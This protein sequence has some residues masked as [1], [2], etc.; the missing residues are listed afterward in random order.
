MLYV[1]ADKAASAELLDEGRQPPVP[2]NQDLPQAAK[3]GS[4]RAQ[5]GPS[6][7]WHWGVDLP[8]ATDTAVVAPERMTIAYVWTDNTT[9]PF[10]GYGPAGVL[11]QGKSGRWHLLAHLDPKAWTA[12]GAAPPAPQKVYEK[13]E[14][15]GFPSP[16]GGEGVGTAQPHT[17]WEVRVNPID[18]PSTRKANTLDPIAWLGGVDRVKERS[19]SGGLLILLALLLYGSRKR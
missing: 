11:A 15:V 3:Y 14:Q 12:E 16:T 4:F 10:A 18:A 5:Q 6:G 2:I 8:A 1:G 19:G 17:H 13:G 9:A 7:T